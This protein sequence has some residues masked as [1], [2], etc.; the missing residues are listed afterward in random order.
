[1][2]F[3]GNL[4]IKTLLRR[5]DD[6]NEAGNYILIDRYLFKLLFLIDSSALW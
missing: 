4:R 5:W 2:S 6:E 3:C 1:M